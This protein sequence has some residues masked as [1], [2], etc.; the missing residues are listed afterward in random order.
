M[1]TESPAFWL[2]N[3]SNRNISLTD[4]NLTVRAFS[5]I[6]LLDSKHYSYTLDQLNLS[7]TKG[8]IFKKRKMLTVRQIAP[9][10]TK[11]NVPFNKETFIPSRERSILSIKEENYDELNLSDEEFA[12]DNADLVS[13]D[14]KTILEKV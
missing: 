7:V 8:S 11:M 13:L 4:L 10:V 6:N 1:K 2:T 12:K 3:F 9:I 14:V 5:S